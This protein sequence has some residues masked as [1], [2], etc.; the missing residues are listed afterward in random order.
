MFLFCHGE[1][2]RDMGDA[3]AQKHLTCL[4][5]VTSSTV[6]I[7]AVYDLPRTYD[8]VRSSLLRFFLFN[9]VHITEKISKTFKTSYRKLKKRIGKKKAIKAKGGFGTILF[10]VQFPVVL[11]HIRV[12]VP[13]VAI[14]PKVVHVDLQHL[15][16]L[17]S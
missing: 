16:R 12:C 6:W 11:D 1:L 10:Q 8:E 13:Q 4:H 9:S 2:F 3:C 17:L 14:L 15:L 5:T 7:S